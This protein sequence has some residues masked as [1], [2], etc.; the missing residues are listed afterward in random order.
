MTIT[1]EII[2]PRDCIIALGIPQTR[3][4]F[5]RDK[6]SRVASYA[7]Y[8]SNWIHYETCI[9]TP[10]S[11]LMDLAQNLQLDVVPELTCSKVHSLFEAPAHKVVIIISHYDQTRGTI[12]LS[13]IDLGLPEFVETIPT[14]FIGFLDSPCCNV[15]ELGILLRQRRADCRFRYRHGENDPSIWFWFYRILLTYFRNNEVTYLQAV[16]AVVQEMTKR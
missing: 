3:E 6:A 4:A 11:K 5:Q 15:E 12:E 2:K 13:D 10:L 8:Y 9:T 7:S 1:S 16:E 14:D